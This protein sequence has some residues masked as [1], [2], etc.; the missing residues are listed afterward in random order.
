MITVA[1]Y[2][3]EGRL[4]DEAEVEDAGAAARASEVLQEDAVEAGYE[5][6]EVTVRFSDE[7]GHDLRLGLDAALDAAA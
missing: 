6:R 5:P 4:I 7:E 1:T 2:N 3:R